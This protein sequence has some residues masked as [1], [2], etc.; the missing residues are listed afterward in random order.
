LEVPST[1]WTGNKPTS[2]E[3]AATAP[4]GSK[5]W[6]VPGTVEHVFTHF[7]LLCSVHRAL[8]PVDAPLTLWADQDRCQWVHRRDLAT[9]GLP[10]VMN[11]IAL[12]G[13]QDLAPS[14]SKKRA[15]RN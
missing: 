10:S 7:R 9:A 12:H 14:E 3:I 5:W 2:E 8:V 4:V 1:S 6:Q 13:L 11:K 15:R